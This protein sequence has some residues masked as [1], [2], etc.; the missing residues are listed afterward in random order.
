VKKRVRTSS[1]QVTKFAFW[2]PIGHDST[3]YSLRKASAANRLLY[4]LDSQNRCKGLPNTIHTTAFTNSLLC[5]NSSERLRSHTVTQEV[6][7]FINKIFVEIALNSSP[8]C[9]D[10]LTDSY[11]AINYTSLTMA[12]QVVIKYGLL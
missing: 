1:P 8:I 7:C 9:T 3:S 2:I 4:I 11:P 10:R 6:C 12:E 5:L